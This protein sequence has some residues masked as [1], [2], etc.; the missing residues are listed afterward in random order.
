MTL[1][2]PNT[3]ASTTLGSDS[4][5]YPSTIIEAMTTTAT[6]TTPTTTG[7]QVTLPHHRTPT[8]TIRIQAT[9]L[10]SH[11]QDH[12]PP[13]RNLDKINGISTNHHHRHHPSHSST[14]PSTRSSSTSNRNL[15]KINGISTKPTSHYSNSP[16]GRDHHHHH[17]HHRHHPA[18]R[19]K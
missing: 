7:T 18:R 11:Q 17:H 10:P 12:H 3:P 13:N 2:E 14:F 6:Q 1:N 8:T 5:E 19:A 4:G 9:L 15:D 16:N